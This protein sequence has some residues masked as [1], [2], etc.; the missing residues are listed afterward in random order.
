MLLINSKN[1]LLSK[2]PLFFDDLFGFFEI[3][4]SI[5]FG[6]TPKMELV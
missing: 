6:I 5:L 4:S 1:D 3:S 2:L